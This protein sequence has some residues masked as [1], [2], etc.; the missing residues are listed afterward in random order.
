MD[1]LS[2]DR[3]Y[4][5]LPAGLLR[6]PGAVEQPDTGQC[7]ALDLHLGSRAHRT[8]HAADTD[9]V[10][11]GAGGGAAVARSYSNLVQPVGGRYRLAIVDSQAGERR[12]A[13]RNAPGSN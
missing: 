9:P 10:A 5:N 4:R 3:R 11:K 8:D 6:S 12:R 1:R 7:T 13:E 2:A